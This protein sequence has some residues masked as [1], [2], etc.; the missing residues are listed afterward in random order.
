MKVVTPH[1]DSTL[2]EGFISMCVLIEAD[3]LGHLSD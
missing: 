3:S 2:N 1:K